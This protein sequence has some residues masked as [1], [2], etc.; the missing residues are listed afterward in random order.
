MAT[1]IVVKGA[2]E[3]NLKNVSVTIPRNQLVVFTGLSGSGKSS[4]A[5]DTIYA[6]GQRRYLE[7]LSA[8]ARQFMEQMRKPD[9]DHIEGLS[10]SISIEQKNISRNP[11]STVGTV[12]EIYDYLRLL[13]ARCGEPHCSNC[14]SPI[15]TQTVQQICD[16]IMAL[17]QGTRFSVLAPVVR[18]KKGEYQKELSEYRAKGFVRA[19]ID[20]AEM[21]LAE[22]IRLKKTFKHDISVYIDRLVLK[23]GI[24]SRLAEALET[25]AG[26]A[27]GLTEF[28]NAS[29]LSTKIYS[30]RF[31]CTAC[32]TSIAEIE[33]RGFS[34]NNP[35]GACEKC[36]GLG[37]LPGFDPEKVIPD[38]SLSLRDGAIAAWA[39]KSKAWQEKILAAL[40]KSYEFSL[41]VPWDQLSDRAKLV[42]LYGTGKEEIDFGAEG[43]RSFHTF[44]QSFEGVIPHL[45]Q[46]LKNG[47]RFDEEELAVFISHND[48]TQCKGTRLKPE[49][50]AVTVGGKNIA[51][52]SG[53]SLEDCAYFFSDLKVEKQHEPIA[54]PIFK[55]IRARLEFLQ[56]V[57][58]SYL[59]LSRSAATLSGGEA[60]R[61]RLGT[62]IGSSMVGVLYVLDE[63]SIGLHQRDNE[64]LIHTLLALRDQGN[65]V[66]VVEH[67]QDTIEAADF[68]VDLGPG[69]GKLGGEIVFEGK[70]KA[71]AAAPRSLTGKYLTG[72]VA[73]PV[74]HK[75]R[76]PNPERQL[77]LK[78]LSKNNLK[79]V[80]V[81]IPLGLFT[82]FSGVSGSG[83]STLVIDSL[84][85][86]LEAM[87][88]RRPLPPGVAKSFAGV[89]HID[90]VV[91]VDQS[92]IGRSPR[93]NPATYTGLFTDVRNLFAS[94]PEA[95]ARGYSL[96]RFSFNVPGGRC[97]ACSGEGTLSVTMHFLPDVFVECE[98]CRGSRFNRETL[99]VLYR[100][101]SIADVLNM[102]IEDAAELFD[103]VPALRTK[104]QTLRDVGLG[105]VHVG[106]SATTLS[107]GEAQRIKLAK[108]LTRRATGK[109][110]YILDEPTT[111]L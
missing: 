55:E 68:L 21:S 35:Q 66:I 104:F 17:P 46:R 93:S 72:E 96:S 87:L 77:V 52:V 4:L 22:T 44:R 18:G 98:V 111:G 15:H 74:P 3:H 14:G 54:E 29:D 109:T 62:Q 50:L 97:E 11:R 83:K 73:V 24:E 13:Y 110:I 38:P 106:Q 53:L 43:K 67:D 42:V 8:Y 99:E 59:T 6:E 95:R 1:E 16:Q 23:P 58:L 5:F 41:D 32:G 94:L 82:C 80:D 92:P 9:V 108:E 56:N 107:G 88:R 90:K 79:N 86:G 40:A 37:A 12:T 33:P 49:A 19:K 51:E 101:K 103:R 70:P 76:A 10:P 102:A 69:A 60:Q 71:I 91:Y 36:N 30:T 47:S 64:K 65:S 45:E 84:M 26:L 39:D 89:E 7:S 20:G 61:I 85:V 31:A 25:A 27:E 48:C 57:G 28:E 78:G 75:R 34:F 105:Y 63:P 81:T 100:G 2:R